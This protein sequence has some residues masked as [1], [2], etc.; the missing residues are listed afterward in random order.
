MQKN[1]VL[2]SYR[3]DRFY[4]YLG[5]P[6]PKDQ[7][8]SKT[9]DS[10]LYSQFPREAGTLRYGVLHGKQQGQSGG[11]GRGGN[12]GQEPLLW[13]LWEERG[14]PESTRLGLAS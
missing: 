14:K 12:C 1:E 3:F 11:R 13:F 5:M 4:Y 8:M 6:R 2:F 7:E 10:L 9:E